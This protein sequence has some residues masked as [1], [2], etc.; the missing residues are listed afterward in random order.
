MLVGI[1]PVL[2]A[3]VACSCALRSS[4]RTLGTL[5]GGILLALLAVLLLLLR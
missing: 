4:W 1:C 3:S 2:L 5:Y